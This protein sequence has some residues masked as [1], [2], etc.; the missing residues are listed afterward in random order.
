MRCETVG[1]VPAPVCVADRPCVPAR[2]DVLY[3][4]RLHRLGGLP[5]SLDLTY[6]PMD[7]GAAQTRAGM[8]R[9]LVEV[10]EGTRATVVLV[11]HD[12]DEALFLGDRVAL[13]GGTEGGG[14]VLDIPHPRQR[15]AHDTAATVASRRQVLESLGM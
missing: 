12:V 6:L 1:P 15:A 2:T 5:L 10:L 8:R 7:I 13:L 11:A 14:R 3:V 4:E 9:L